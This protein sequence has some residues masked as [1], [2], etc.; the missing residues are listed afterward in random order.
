MGTECKLLL[1]LLLLLFVIS[2]VTN[3]R[4]DGPNRA[5]GQTGN[6]TNKQATSSSNNNNKADGDGDNNSSRGRYAWLVVHTLGHNS[7]SQRTLGLTM[8]A[9]EPT[10]CHTAIQQPHAQPSHPSGN[11]HKPV[12]PNPKQQWRPRVNVPVHSRLLFYSLW[13]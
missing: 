10:C 7:D 11:A 9:K 12:T 4:Y 3:T 8:N 5:N 1:L 2:S 6:R 13:L